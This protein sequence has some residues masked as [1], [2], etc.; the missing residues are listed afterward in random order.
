MQTSTSLK[1]SRI[2][3]LKSNKT[4]TST[5]AGHFRRFDSAHHPVSEKIL[6]EGC[7][8][9][10]L[11]FAE[12]TQ[13]KIPKTCYWAAKIKNQVTGE[14]VAGTDPSNGN[15]ALETS[16]DTMEE[17]NSWES[18]FIQWSGKLL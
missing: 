7:N 18:K 9:N 14:T 5:V 12:V 1:K 3:C 15:S 4:T 11:S 13:H 16:S 6:T 8:G 17:W 2:L 10:A